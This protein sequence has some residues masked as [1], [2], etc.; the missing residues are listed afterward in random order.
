MKRL[1]S[2]FALI[3]YAHLVSTVLLPAPT[4]G[5]TQETTVTGTFAPTQF[6]LP[7]STADR[8]D[9]RAATI[10]VPQF[11]PAM[12]NVVGVRISTTSTASLGV[13]VE[14]PLPRSFPTGVNANMNAQYLVQPPGG[15]PSVG[16]STFFNKTVNLD[17][18]QTATII[19]YAGQSASGGPLD[20]T[21]FQTFLGHGSVLIPLT[22]T[23]DQKAFAS[24]FLNNL[25]RRFTPTTTT[26]VSVTYS[27]IALPTA[28]QVT[29]FSR[30]KALFAEK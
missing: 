28:T 9:S 16:S 14:I 18:G 26:T 27:Y 30:I 25:S 29:T 3:V 19:G 11:D 6:V 20:M 7:L 17:P 23:F 1:R 12:G 5:Q 24:G 13:F 15:N 22:M 10:S 21:N 2:T 4:M 8:V